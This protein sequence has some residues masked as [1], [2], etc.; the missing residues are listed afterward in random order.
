MADTRT[1]KWTA[2]NGSQIEINMVLK[3]I[4]G[5]MEVDIDTTV[6]G[7]TLGGMARLEAIDHPQVAAKISNGRKA[8]GLSQEN[9]NR[10][11]TSLAEL[12]SIAAPE[13]SARD[14]HEYAVES[15]SVE[16]RRIERAIACGELIHYLD[17][18]RT[19]CWRAHS[20]KLSPCLLAAATI[21]WYSVSAK[22]RPRVLSRPVFGRPGGRRI[23]NSMGRPS[24]VS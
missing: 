9:L 17:N 24:F 11:N 4:G 12:E 13:N 7:E 21:R 20:L 8:V 1:I 15:V 16:R 3:D 14:R 22:R 6:D 18:A 10:Y 5:R 23:S 2:G 19:S